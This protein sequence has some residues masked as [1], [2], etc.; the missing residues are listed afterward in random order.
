MLVEHPIMK[1]MMRS[2]GAN[3]CIVVWITGPLIFGDMGIEKMRSY[4][5]VQTEFSFFGSVG[6]ACTDDCHSRAEKAE[7][8]QTDVNH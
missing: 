5:F 4:V 6:D 3:F 8:Q 2:T 1:T 7:C